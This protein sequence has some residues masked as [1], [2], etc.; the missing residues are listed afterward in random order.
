MDIITGWKQISKLLGDIGVKTL[1][2][3]VRDRE[4][5][6]KKVGG[7]IIADKQEIIIWIKSQPRQGANNDR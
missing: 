5:P 2:K 7:C 6:V 1:K 3:W 4:L